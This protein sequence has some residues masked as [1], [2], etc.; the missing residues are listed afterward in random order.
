M[1]DRSSAGFWVIV[2]HLIVPVF[3]LGGV[4][5]AQTEGQAPFFSQRAYAD[6]LNRASAYPAAAAAY[7]ALAARFGESLTALRNPYADV[8]GDTLTQEQLADSLSYYR[9][10]EVEQWQNLSEVER[11]TRLTEGGLADAAA[12]GSS[13]ARGTL[14]A[15]RQYNAQLNADLT[16]ILREGRTA[17]HLLAPSAVTRETRS[18]VM[19][20]MASAF[21]FAGEVD[22]ALSYAETVLDTLR[23]YYEPCDLLIGYAHNNQSVLWGYTNESQKRIEHLL[24]A[25]NV[26]EESLPPDHAHHILIN[27]N[28]ASAYLSYGDVPRGL[29]ALVHAVALGRARGVRDNFYARTATLYTALLTN[30][31]DEEGA[32]IWAREAYEAERSYLPRGHPLLVENL[33]RLAAAEF[34]SGEPVR[35]K[36]L[37]DSADA[38]SADWEGETDVHPSSDHV[39][40]II[41]YEEGDY[42]GAEKLIRRSLALPSADTASS[43]FAMSRFV[44]GQAIFAQGRR[45]EGLKRSRAAQRALEIMLDGATS[46]TLTIQAAVLAQAFDE[47][48]RPDS[49]VHYI[50][51]AVA[52]TGI[53]GDSAASVGINS[54]L[55]ECFFEYLR[56]RRA[57]PNY[58]WPYDARAIADYTTKFLE[59][60]TAQIPRIAFPE[61]DLRFLRT[62]YLA[63]AAETGAAFRQNEEA[64]TY[65]R[66]RAYL[67]VPRAMNLRNRV[68]TDSAAAGAMLPDSTKR[69]GSMLRLNLA[70]ASS[71]PVPE[72]SADR[73][74]RERQLGRAQREL[75]GY[76]AALRQNYPAY[77]ALMYRPLFDV[78]STDPSAGGDTDLAFG[79]G[80]ATVTLQIDAEAGRLLAAAELDGEHRWRSVPF[81]A[82]DSARLERFVATVASG[83]FEG[84]AVDGY[85]LYTKLLDSLGLDSATHLQIAAEGPLLKVPFAALLTSAVEEGARPDEWPWLLERSVV[86]Y[87]DVYA[88]PRKLTAPGQSRTLAVAPVFDGERR[89][90]DSGSAS[91]RTPWTLGLA[92]W[93]ATEQGADTL[94]RVQATERALRARFEDF[95]VLHLGTHGVLAEDDPLQSYFTLSGGESDAADDGRIYA[96]EIYDAQVGG[97]LAVLPSCN[98]GAG[99]AVAGDG[100][101][102]LATGLR[103][104]G[105]EAVVQ[106]LW[107]VDD[108]QTN[109]ILRPFYSDLF[110]GQ[111]IDES[112]AHAQRSYLAR[113][114]P[115]L[116]HPYYWAGLGVLGNAREIVAPPRPAWAWALL[117]GGLL[118]LSGVGMRMGRT[119]GGA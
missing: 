31:G 29:K 6:S 33:R 39:R 44:L 108:E 22:S 41:A 21:V 97:R 43:I 36:A 84:L 1:R 104:A 9:S 32:R 34:D 10:R 118:G 85:A 112:L 72:L 82:E 49:A 58:D 79:A 107:S 57:Y 70:A 76:E 23:A 91:L 17:L 52:S 111:R 59:R 67:R 66:A 73:L 15:V 64:P 110:A 81:G 20:S 102:S 54:A 40:G 4:L 94:I 115:E 28:L 62:I 86:A 93:L 61:N 3:G 38:G 2:L 13:W 117:V 80:H 77:F 26:F 65:D 63:A 12:R 68:A 99:R 60:R 109:A 89:G 101:Y 47:V 95:D 30:L 53:G 100:V 113:V 87:E 56:I 18:E 16:G 5:G 98:S 48:D 96:Y 103:Y 7:G 24:L 114:A 116:Q 37:L 55:P 45:E 78:V 105:C 69:R 90:G 51:E 42:A 14:A 119:R 74:D 46:S 19:Q 27:N 11:A 35:A 92:E 83:G 88:T 8:Q 71:R 25:R 106:S 75:A 50:L